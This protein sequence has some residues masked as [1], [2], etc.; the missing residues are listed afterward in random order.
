[1]LTVAAFVTDG[2]AAATTS[3]VS[4]NFALSPAAIGAA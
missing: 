4:V 2:N 1:M 3:T